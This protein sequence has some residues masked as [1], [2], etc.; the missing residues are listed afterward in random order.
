MIMEEAVDPESDTS[1][2]R[3]IVTIA[4]I[5]IAMVSATYVLLGRSRLFDVEQVQIYGIHRMN[6]MEVEEHLGFRR[7]DPL[8]SVNSAEVR[9]NLEL[10]PWV[11]S[12]D[13]ERGWNGHIKIDVTERQAIALAMVAPQQWALIDVT[14]RVLT[15]ALPYPPDLPRLSGVHAAG[16][17]GSY[18]A[19]D[20]GALLV[21]LAALPVELR[22]QFYS[23]RRDT[24]GEI[25]GSLKGGEDIVFG[26]DNKLSAKVIVLATVLSHLREQNR[27]DQFIDVSLPHEPRVRSEA[28]TTSTP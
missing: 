2:T 11:H 5:T 18:M 21:V 15:R 17:P 24:S 13:I 8:L 4:A 10:L 23:L 7:G 9:R 19:S 22:Q 28:R 16:E 14:G 20:S 6:V 12:A 26:D 1:R 27:N 25:E 3:R